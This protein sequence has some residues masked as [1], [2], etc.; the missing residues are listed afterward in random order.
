MAQILVVDDD[1]LTRDTLRQILEEE[2]H[3]IVEAQC[4]IE[5]ITQL[6]ANPVNL[7]VT[8]VIM[9]GMEGI[10]MISTLRNRGYAG[11]IVA[12]SGA[13]SH[14]AQPP[15]RLALAAGADQVL[16]K[17]FGSKDLL[18]VVRACLEE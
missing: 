6:E 11:P 15:L 8:D 1:T 9:P 7:I 13:S 18:A 16:E 2:Q 10:E 14:K 5:A 12:I 17:P 3:K 4:G